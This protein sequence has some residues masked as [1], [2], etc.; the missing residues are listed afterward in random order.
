MLKKV[1]NIAAINIANKLTAVSHE[2]V[3]K[4]TARK[5]IPIYITNPFS[6][7]EKRIHIKMFDK[8]HEN[9]FPKSNK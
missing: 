8:F 4:H 7:R 5:V 3:I 6:G 2:S 1:G 9:Y